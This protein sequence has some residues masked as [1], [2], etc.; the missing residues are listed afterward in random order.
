MPIAIGGIGD[1]LA[2]IGLV[3]EFASALNDSRGSAAD[4]QEVRRELDGLE[5]ALLC[6][7]QLLQARSH[8]P[9]LNAIFVSTQSTA[10]D[11]QRCIEAFS[12]QIV[13]FYGTLGVGKQ[14]NIAKEITMKLRWQMSRKDEVSAM[15]HFL[16]WHFILILEQGREVS[17]DPGT[18]HF[19]LE[20]AL[21]TCKYVR[22][23]FHQVDWPDWRCATEI[24]SEKPT[25]N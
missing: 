16:G 19:L 4:Y 15:S 17:Y 24:C 11:C 6:L 22:I 10:E 13:K 21:C 7:H 8:D 12:Q 5:R 18:A 2:I 20:H 25:R 1:I 3:R 9:A 14:G 23:L